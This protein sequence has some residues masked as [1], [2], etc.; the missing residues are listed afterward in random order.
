MSGKPYRY[1]RGECRTVVGPLLCTATISATCVHVVTAGHISTSKAIDRMAGT[2]LANC[3]RELARVL[4]FTSVTRGS[5]MVSGSISAG[6]PPG[7]R[8]MGYT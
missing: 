4:M 5:H 2:R 6:M 8:S 7:S 1:L 3:T